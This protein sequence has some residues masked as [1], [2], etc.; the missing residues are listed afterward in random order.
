MDIIELKRIISEKTAEFKR[1]VEQI[2]AEKRSFSD[3]EQGKVDALEREINDLHSQ[4]R[5]LEKVSD[6]ERNLPE[7][8]KEMG[9]PAVRTQKEEIS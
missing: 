8:S 2:T 5:A 7:P 4:L 9:A 1:Y 6:F 3:E